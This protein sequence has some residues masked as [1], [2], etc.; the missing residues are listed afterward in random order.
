VLRTVART[1]PRHEQDYRR[2]QVVVGEPPG[3][4]TVT[5]SSDL[6]HLFTPPRTSY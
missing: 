5:A 6:P 2:G 4:D 1:S 3:R